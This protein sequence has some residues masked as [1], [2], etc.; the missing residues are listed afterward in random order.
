[1]AARKQWNRGEAEAFQVKLQVNSDAAL[2]RAFDG[3]APNFCTKSHYL[4]RAINCQKYHRSRYGACAARPESFERVHDPHRSKVYLSEWIAKWRV[5]DFKRPPAFRMPDRVDPSA[6]LQAVYH[7]ERALNPYFLKGKRDNVALVVE[8][9]RN[10]GSYCNF[11]LGGHNPRFRIRMGK[12]PYYM[13][14][15]LLHEI[16]HAFACSKYEP[17]HGPMF[18]GFLLY[19]TAKYFSIQYTKHV[20]AQLWKRAVPVDIRI[21]QD[22]AE[23]LRAPE[24]Q[25]WHRIETR[26]YRNAESFVTFR[27]PAAGALLI[28]AE[29]QG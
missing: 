15:V 27:T 16:A 4:D 28:N 1:M 22:P 8:Q 19:L 7:N 26:Y 12:E 17:P 25:E 6:W 13:R 23:W 9:S 24:V 21:A 3:Y 10:M 29:V 14:D 20:L 5:S 2:K 18:C 11:E